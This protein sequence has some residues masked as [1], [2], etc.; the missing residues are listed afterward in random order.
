VKLLKLP[1]HSS[2]PQGFRPSRRSLAA[3]PRFFRRPPQ[4]LNFRGPASPVLQPT[5][6][7]RRPIWARPSARGRSRHGAAAW[8]LGVRALDSLGSAPYLTLAPLA[9][10]LGHLEPPPPALRQNRRRPL[11]WN[12][13]RSRRPPPEVSPP[14][15]SS[16]STLSIL[17]PSSAHRCPE[18]RRPWPPGPPPP[19]P[20]LLP[21]VLSWGRRWHP[22]SRLGPSSFQ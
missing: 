10:A 4:P 6:A 1:N 18:R 22:V 13:S 2:K 15:C 12:A 20:L 21:C 19:P 8:A 17:C 7:L 14:S 5:V 3:A 16:R 9:R 11:T